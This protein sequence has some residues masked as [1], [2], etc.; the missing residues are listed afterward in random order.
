MGGRHWQAAQSSRIGGNWFS[1]DLSKSVKNCVFFNSNF[2]VRIVRSLIK[3]KLRYQG[4]LLSYHALLVEWNL[5]RVIAID[6]GRCVCQLDLKNPTGTYYCMPVCTWFI[7]DQVRIL[8]RT[9]ATYI[10]WIR[11][12]GNC[13]MA[14]IACAVDDMHCNVLEFHVFAC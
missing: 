14:P 13:C 9:R 11:Y 8:A 3:P 6:V 1:L 4:Q 7:V 10:N 12:M 5:Y 2:W